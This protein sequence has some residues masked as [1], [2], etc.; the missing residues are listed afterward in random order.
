MQAKRITGNKFGLV[1][2]SMVLILLIGF[3]DFRTGSEISFSLFYLFPLILVSVSEKS[4]KILVILIAVFSSVIWFLADYFIRE[5]PNV[6]ISLWNAFVRLSIFLVFGLLVYNIKAQQRK[7][8]IINKGLQDL[9]AEKNKFIG[10]AAH[11]IRNPISTIFSFS[12]LLLTEDEG[13][14]DEDVI[15]KLNYIRELSKNA[16]VLLKDLLDVS[17]IETGNVYYSLKLHN[18]IDFLSTR[19]YMNQLL[20]DKKDIKIS[21]EADDPALSF[22]FD[23]KYL[24]EVVD[25]LLTNAIKYSNPGS[26]VVVR[27]SVMP[28]GNIRTDVIDEGIGIPADEQHKLFQYFQK[29]SSEPTGGEGSTGLGL[30]IA[31]K[32]VTIH[33]GYIGVKSEPGIGSEFYF[34]LPR[35][36]RKEKGQPG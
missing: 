3:I 15:R 28:N 24:A 32:I 20:A 7:I 27:V 33:E 35:Q 36:I 10:I 25:N 21:L 1:A 8:R 2:F 12:D 19:I 30:A 23:E 11:D 29:T 14:F 13:R 26:R 4:G 34:E 6:I 5:Y 17:K 16:L 22:Y 31:K 18:Y 9:N